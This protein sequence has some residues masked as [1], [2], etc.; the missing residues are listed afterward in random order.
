M[1]QKFSMCVLS[2][3]VMMQI[4]LLNYGNACFSSVPLKY[5]NDVAVTLNVET[6]NE[7]SVL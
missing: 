2:A 5:W 7:M 4:L 1:P 3:V 6:T